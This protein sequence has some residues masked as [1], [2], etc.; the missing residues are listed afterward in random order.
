MTIQDLYRMEILSTLSGWQ[1]RE[2]IEE[3]KY[4]LKRGEVSYDDARHRAEPIIAE[5]N[6]RGERICKEAKRRWRPFTFSRLM[7]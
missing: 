6:A 1:L 3:V 4:L 2:K 7:H 5:M